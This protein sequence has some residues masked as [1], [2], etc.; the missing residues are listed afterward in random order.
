MSFTPGERRALMLSVLGTL[1]WTLDVAI[2]HLILPEAQK[3]LGLTFTDSQWIF[4]ASLVGFVAFGLIGGWVGDSR[5][6]TWPFASVPASMSCR[7]QRESP[8]RWPAMGRC[9]F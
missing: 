5:A 3:S 6:R 1:I 8:S 2:T 7:A 9:S 4:A